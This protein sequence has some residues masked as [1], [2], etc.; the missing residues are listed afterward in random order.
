[1]APAAFF[2]QLIFLHVEIIITNDPRH[3]IMPNLG[4]T[5][6]VKADVI[7]FPEIKHVALMFVVDGSIVDGFFT[8][9]SGI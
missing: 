7:L 1:M 8:P 6:S 4:W 2:L 3:R 5:T 9:V